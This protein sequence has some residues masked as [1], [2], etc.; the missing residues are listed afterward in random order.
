MS[1]TA[2]F[3]RRL[4]SRTSCPSPRSAVVRLA[5][6]S[7]LAGGL[8]GCAVVEVA[9]AAAGAAIS[10]TGAVISTGVHVTGKVVEKTIDIV[11][12]GSSN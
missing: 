10:V 12:P 5:A 7:L 8:C 2:S 1:M 3:R 4:L 6:A 11:T 9:G